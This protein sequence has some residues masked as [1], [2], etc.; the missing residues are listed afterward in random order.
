MGPC[1]ALIPKFYYDRDQKKCR[2][3]KYGGC[4]GNANNFHSRKLCEHTCGNKEKVPWVCR[5]AVRTYPCDKPNTEFFFNLKTMTCEP[6][7]PGLCSRTTNVFPEEA[8]C[9]SLCE[10]RKSIPSFCSSPK[11]EGLCSANVTR[12]YFNSR[13]KACETFTYT[14][15][16]GNE[17]NFY[18]L[19]A[20][21]RACVKALKKP[22]R[23]KIGDF[24]PRFWK[25]RS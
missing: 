11:D 7:R 10:P 23:R 3:F 24:L 16:G 2:R 12:Y 20:C 9:K 25:L 8:M 17:N 6:L 4:L 15:C 21:N 14:G 13:N 19:D 5:S 18:Y 1:K 22:K